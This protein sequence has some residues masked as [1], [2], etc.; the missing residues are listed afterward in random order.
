MSAAKEIILGVTGSIASYKACDIAGGLVKSGFKVTPI[1]TAEAEEFITPL[2]MQTMARGKVFTGMFELPD[3]YDPIH[4]GLADRADLILIAPATANIIGK[5][6]SGICDDLLT[7]VVF[8]SKAPV[9]IAPAMNENM[10]THKIIQ[11]Q[12]SKLKAVGYRFVGPVKGRLASGRIGAGHIAPIE[13]IIRLAKQL[14][15]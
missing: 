4:I 5:L 14:L 11:G 3:V 12:I 2:A 10:Y 6:A 7:C 9:L 1:L 13:E 8:A 15:K